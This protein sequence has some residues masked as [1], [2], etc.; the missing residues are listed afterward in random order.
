MHSTTFGEKKPNTS[1]QHK[2]FIRTVKHGGGR[3]ILFCRLRT[4]ALICI[5]K[6]SRVKCGAKAWLNLSHVNGHGSQTQQQI[7]NKMADKVK[8]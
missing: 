4:W 7:Y 1:Y 3:L 8:N 5:L 6:Y 2:H